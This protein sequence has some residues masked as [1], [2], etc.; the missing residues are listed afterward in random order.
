MPT[1]PLP[2]SYVVEEDIPYPDEDDCFHEP[3]HVEIYNSQ[4]SSFSDMIANHIASIRRFR[5]QAHSLAV[6]SFT[7]ATKDDAGKRKMSP[8]ERMERIAKGRARK[9][10]RP[11]FDPSRYQELCELAIAEL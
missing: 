7:F 8:E 10:A 11:R 2:P 5:A 4:L 3:D 9:W 6:S 1:P